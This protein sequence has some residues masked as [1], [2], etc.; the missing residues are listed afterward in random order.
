MVALGMRS[1]LI[2][3]FFLLFR[4]TKHAT[5]SLPGRCPGAAAI[6]RVAIKKDFCLKRLRAIG[7]LAA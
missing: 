6:P 7:T 5:R 2:F 3:V 1:F 4:I